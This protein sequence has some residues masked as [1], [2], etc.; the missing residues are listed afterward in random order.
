MTQPNVL[1]QTAGQ[2][3]KLFTMVLWKLQKDKAVSLTEQDIKDFM[4]AH[5]VE[6]GKEP[7][8]IMYVTEDG[9]RFQVLSQ[10]RAAKFVEEY[11]AANRGVVL[12]E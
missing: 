3:E 12:G 5:D 1:V 2:L 7:H 4:A 11:K 8:L 10:E 9:L 6:G